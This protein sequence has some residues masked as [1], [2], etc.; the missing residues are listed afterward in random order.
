MREPPIVYDVVVVETCLLKM[1]QVRRQGLIPE[2]RR[3][4][5]IGVT[6]ALKIDAIERVYI[7]DHGSERLKLRQPAKEH[8][9]IRFERKEH[10]PVSGGRKRAIFYLP[11]NHSEFDQ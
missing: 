9:Y 6:T 10:D 8:I 3:L 5:G 4:C 1:E 11:T 2:E 7:D